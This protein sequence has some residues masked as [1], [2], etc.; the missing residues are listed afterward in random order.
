MLGCLFRLLRNILAVIGLITVIVVIILGVA[1]WQLT[2]TPELEGKMRPIEFAE[3]QAVFYADKFDEKVDELEADLKTI[4]P[5]ARV[6]ISF[7]EEEATAKIIEEI[8]NADIPLDIED[9]WLNFHVDEETGAEQVQLLGKVDVGF[10]TLKA[11]VVMEMTIDSNGEPAITV[12]ELAVGSGFLIPDQAKEL[13]ADA[14]PSEEA[15]TDMINNL[16]I[17]LT[18][19][20][21][22]E[23]E[24]TFKGK[25]E[26]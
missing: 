18:E 12:D 14:I 5:G 22:T 16:P 4:S 21:I 13:V 9:V 7:T 11:G 2:K 25:K 24:L 19:I 1:F 17:D 20:K 6:E 23:G 10:T 8:E 26:Y 15:L 3:G